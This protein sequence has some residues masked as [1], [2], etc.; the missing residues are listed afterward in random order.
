M[1]KLCNEKTL[2]HVY[3]EYFSGEQKEETIAMRFGS[4][5]HAAILEQSVFDD[6]YVIVPEAIKF[7]T[8][9]GKALKKDIEASGKTAIKETEFKDAKAMAKQLLSSLKECEIDIHQGVWEQPLLI[10]GARCKPD[11]LIR[12]E[13]D[14]TKDDLAACANENNLIQ[15]I[16]LKSCA[17][18]SP[19]GFQRAAY[20]LGYHI[21]AS[22]Y[23]RI[24]QI[25]WPKH[26]IEFIFA[27]V[28]KKA[29]YVAQC[30]KA[31]EEL[32]HAGNLVCYEMAGCINE[33]IKNNEWPGYF[34]G[35]GL[36]EL[37]DWALG[38]QL[39]FND[40]NEEN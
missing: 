5:F 6:R 36:L 23:T 27:C 14:F 1:I 13:N 8:K 32:I 30:Y 28:E 24:A 25:L 34:S 2:A 12:K 4:M 7:N 20:R 40:N 29:P 10:E 16:D 22:W 11:I 31:T 21:Q 19:V 26:R 18:A 37:P 3:H 33:A 9:E 17:D 15:I 38:E 35:M 39:D